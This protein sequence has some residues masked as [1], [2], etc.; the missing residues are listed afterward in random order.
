ML[1]IFVF[2]NMSRENAQKGRRHPGRLDASSS[3]TATAKHLVPFILAALLG[4]PGGGLAQ[5]QAQDSGPPSATASGS[6]RPSGDTRASHAGGHAAE[7]ELPTVTVTARHGEE[8]AVDVPFGVSAISGEE[9]ELRRART[10]EEAL[11]GTAGVVVNSYGGEP[12]SANILIRGNGSLNQVSVE[13]SSVGLMIDGVSFAV[14]DINMGTLDVERIEILKGPQGTLFGG[15]SQAGAVNIVTRRPT[16]LFEGHVRAEYGKDRQHLEEVVVSGPLSERLSGRFALRGSGGEHWIDNAQDGKPI[17]KPTHL[18]LRGSLFWEIASGTNLLFIAERNKDKHSPALAVLRP[19][20]RA[21]MDFTPGLFDGDYK[22]VERYSA[23]FNHDLSNSRITSITAYNTVDYVTAS[24]YDRRVM[25]ALYGMPIE[26]ENR[27]WSRRHVASQDLRWSSLPG[28]R[29]FWVAGLN[30][31]RSR[32]S[33]DTLTTA[34]GNSANRDYESDSRAL[35]GEVTYP[36]TPTLKLTGGLRHSWDRKRYDALYS[37]AVDDRRKLDDNY[38]TGRVAL[39]CALAPGLNLY[40]ALSH[41]HQSG[42][43]GDFTTQV[44]DSTPYKASDSNALEVG[45]KM[46]SPDRR[47][48]LNG[49]LFMTKVKDDHLLGYDYAT[50]ATNTIN[51]DTESRGAELEGVWRIG[52]GLE[53]Q[54][55]L[56]Y[57]RARITNDVLGVSGGDV[58]SGN[59]KTDVPRW[60]GNV[61]LSHHVHLPEF[62]GLAAPALD[63]RLSYRY[64]GKRPADA[65]NHYTLDSYRKLDLRVGVVSGST[66]IYLYGDNL[67]DE[68]YE[69]FGYWAMPNVTMGAPARGR[70]FGVGMQVFF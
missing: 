45:F 5:A 62:M 21:P 15:N 24:L 31:S 10:V 58:Q 34:T 37:G 39:S 18:A 3:G 6:A 7:A 51:A 4:L 70:T 1:P 8:R 16:R 52:Q 46:E 47:L 33:F 22:T 55:G 63:S 30:L 43:F 65:Q 64:V 29:V 69:H 56:S 36:F 61:A 67:L 2:R 26:N 50:Y 13:D 59:R 9:V 48:S 40:G 42:G 28:A 49:A 27:T 38:T 54:G 25:Q 66:E 20:T 57:V 41:G 14:R 11:T 23:E 68:E 12:N 60:S 17:A 32:R 44:A 19:Y 53:L 35:Y